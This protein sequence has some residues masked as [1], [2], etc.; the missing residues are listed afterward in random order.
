M[1]CGQTATV[2]TAAERQSLLLLLAAVAVAANLLQ[3][4]LHAFMRYFHQKP[5]AAATAAAQRKQAKEMRSEEPFT[6]PREARQRVRE[7]GGKREKEG[8]RGRG[9][10]AEKG[11]KCTGEGSSSPVTAATF[12]DFYLQL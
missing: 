3:L 8:E 9:K 1:T 11:R 5:T 6:G 2:A 12:V 10:A 7:R 4:Q